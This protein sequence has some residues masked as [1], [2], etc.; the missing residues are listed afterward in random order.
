[1]FLSR[2]LF[3]IQLMFRSHGLTDTAMRVKLQLMFQ[4]CKE[5]IQLMKKLNKT[6]EMNE[7]RMELAEHN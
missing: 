1:M 6:E 3:L 5:K 2:F 4:L 7:H